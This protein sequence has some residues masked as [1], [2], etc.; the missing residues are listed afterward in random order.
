[1]QSRFV[2]MI[3]SWSQKQNSLVK[4]KDSQK[5]E[6][7]AKRSEIL[8]RELSVRGRLEKNRLPVQ[9]T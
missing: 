7:E 4:S 2:L 6:S 3:L 5:Y 8:N 9:E 1:M